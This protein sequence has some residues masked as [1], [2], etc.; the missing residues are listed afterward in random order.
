[1]RDQKKAE[2]IAVHRFQL[3]SP[4]LGEGLDGDWFELH[5][6]DGR[7]L[8]CRIELGREWHIIVGRN[9]TKFYLK[10][11]EIYQV[12]LVLGGARAGCEPPPILSV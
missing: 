2:E 1:M 11:N 5:L 7:K 3:I 4:L 8:S 9:D 6:G 10:T 12:Y